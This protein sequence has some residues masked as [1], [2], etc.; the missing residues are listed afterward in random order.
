MLA[1]SF[2]LILAVL[3]LFQALFISIY[4]LG[5]KKG[6]R[7][8]NILLAFIL[9]GLTIRVAKSVIGYYIPLEGWQRNI[10]IAGTLLSGPCLWFYGI[11]IL[12]KN[13]SFSVTHYLPHLV[14]FFLFVLLI[15][16]VPSEGEFETSGTMD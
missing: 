9:L 16:I 10:G 4:L 7:T 5:L 3:G 15:P 8:S 13:K 12:E 1:N 11:S 14:P 2:I 6:N